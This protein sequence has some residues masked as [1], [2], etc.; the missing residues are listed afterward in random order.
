ME[1]PAIEWWKKSKD[2]WKDSFNDTLD[3]E[4]VLEAF[5]KLCTLDDLYREF[6]DKVSLPAL[7]CDYVKCLKLPGFELKLPSF[8]LPPFP[9]VPIIGWY[10]A[11]I[12]LLKKQWRQ[13]LIRILCSFVRTIIDKL[14]F[15]FCEEQLE[16][17]IAAGSSASDVLNEALIDSFLNTGVPNGKEEESK[18]FFQDAANILTP[19]E[20]C[21]CL[22]GKQL[23][24]ATMTILQRLVEKNN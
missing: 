4:Q 24:P 19:E 10:D 13:I 15:P 23:N 9:K 11:L 22:S 6:F 21:H 17:F 7:L 18:A 16:E 12:D 5:G 2:N 14:A 20:L 3:E 8:K 1:D